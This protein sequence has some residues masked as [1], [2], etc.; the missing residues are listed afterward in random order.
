MTEENYS[1]D[2]TVHGER[3]TPVEL[4]GPADV[5]V[6]PDSVEDHLQL[7]DVEYV[8][9]GPPASGDVDP[10]TPAQR[11]R[12]DIEDG[13]IDR[14]GVAGSA[15]VAD[16]ADVYVAHDAVEGQIDV[17][18]AEQVFHDGQTPARAP[19]AGDTT[20]TGWQRS[21]TIDD[22]QGGVALA[23]AGH[24]VTV[25]DAPDGLTLYLTGYDHEVR[26][27][28]GPATVSVHVVGRDNLV[29]TGPYVEATIE[30]ESG[31]DNAVES[32]PVP[33]EA[34]IETSKSEAFGS[35]TFGRSRVTY[36]APATDEQWCP[37]CGTDADAIVE[38][39]SR[40]AFF[41]FG[42][43][44]YTFEAGGESYNCE[45]CATYSVGAQLSESERRDVL[46]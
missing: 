30:S 28:G 37:N 32:D 24:E 36:Q 6:K 46:R 12:G 29:S 44:L 8:Y 42:V 35:V 3:D 10:P 25:T 23:G 41:L 43:P 11:F 19:R 21:R 14:D 9:S 5:F 2:V 40:D 18:G 38:R 20:L 34:V 17:D 45:A 26:L 7:R 31:Y 27:E 1:G 22:P 16:A 13:Y 15:I 39:H 4:A 33:A